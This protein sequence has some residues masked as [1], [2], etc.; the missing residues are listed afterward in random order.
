MIAYRGHYRWV[1][2]AEQI[3]TLRRKENIPL[4]LRENGVYLITGGLGRIGL[5]L[6]KYLAERVR[7]KIALVDR[8]ELPAG[9]TPSDWDIYVSNQANSAQI[10]KQIH[11]LQAIIA[12]GGEVQIYKADVAD[13]D[14]MSG[15]VQ[16]IE[17]RFGSINGVVHAA[18]IVGE[19]AIKPIIETGLELSEIQFNPK[20]FGTLTLAKVFRDK[21]L[22]FIFLQSSLSS[23]LGG[24]GMAAY[25]SANYFM[26]VF[27]SAQKQNGGTPWISVDWDGW[28]FDGQH[29]QA[30]T[31]TELTM[32]S[33]EGVEVFDR[34]MSTEL[35]SRVIISTADMD[36]RINRW[37]KKSLDIDTDQQEIDGKPEKKPI[38]GYQRPDLQTPYLPPRNELEDSIVQT[39]EKV[40]G[41]EPIGVNDDF[42]EL[43]GHSLLAT[44][45]VSRLRDTFNVQLPLRRLFESAT[46]AGISAIL[47]DAGV[48][49]GEVWSDTDQIPQSEGFNKP[50]LPVLRDG[51]LQL[52][53]GQQRLWFLDQM[54]PESPLYNNFS[55]IKFA[56]DLNIEA[57]QYSMMKI[58]D[59]H[60]ILRTTFH[61]KGGRPIQLV[62]EDMVV[63][64]T[65][66]DLRD[67]DPQ[68]AD[69]EF[70]ELALAEARKPFYLDQG[71]MLRTS[72]IRL[73]NQ[74][75]IVLLTMHHI[76]SDG[77]S[78]RV[79][80]EEV[81]AF[82]SAYLDLEPAKI[83]SFNLDDLPIQYVDFAHW[84]RGWLQNEVLDQQL[85]YWREQL[86]NRV[87][88]TGNVEIYPDYP[89]PAF[90]TS[91]GAS[92]WF[93]MPAGLTA[94]LVSLSKKTGVTLFMLLMAA[95]KTLIFRYTGQIDISIGTPIANRTRIETESLIGF[96]LNTLVMRTDLSGNPSF[97]DLLQRE[98]EVAL[99][100]YAHQD[101]PFEMV[102]EALQPE[103]DLSR[104]PFFQIIFDL[105]ESPLTEL[106]LPGLE[107]ASLRVDSGTA[108]FD[109]AL[110][111]EMHTDNQTTDKLAGFFNYNID[112]YNEQTISQ[113][114]NHWIRLIENAVDNPA[115]PI[116]E[117]EIL[118]NAEKQTLLA[119]WSQR[120]RSK[121][122]E[123]FVQDQFSRQ[124]LRTPTAIAITEVFGIFAY[125]QTLSYME[126]EQ[127][128]NQLAHYLKKLGVGPDK[129][130]GVSLRRSIDMI[131]ALLG[132]LKAGG[133]FLPLD[134]TYPIGRV[135]YM[136]T[137]SDVDILLTQER[138]L[139]NL[140]D[141]ISST[142][143]IH[144]LCLDR[145]WDE[146]AQQDVNNPESTI[147]PSNLAYV[148][149]TSGST[150]LPK[151][152]MVTHNDF[153][154]H[155]HAISEHFEISDSD[156]I[157]QFASLNF[158]AAL[159]QIFTSL[160]AGANLFIRGEEIWPTEEFN[161]IVQKLDL[162]VVN[163]PPVYWHHWSQ[164][165]ADQN[166]GERG[167]RINTNK[168]L[169][170]VI[171]GGDVMQTESLALWQK[172]SPRTV[173]LLNAYGPTETTITSMTYEVDP[174]SGK[175]APDRLNR[176]PIGHPTVN[177]FVFILDRAGNPVPNGVPGELCIG[178]M[179]VARGYL[180]NPSLTAERF[181]PNQFGDYLSAGGVPAEWM[182]KLY[183]TGD[184]VRYQPDG[185][186]EFLGRIDDQ[187]KVRGFRIEIGEI[188]TVIQRHP[189]ISECAVILR[190]RRTDQHNEPDQEV[191]KQLVAYVVPVEGKEPS[192][193]E[194]FDHI[195]DYLPN[196]MV[197]A[198]II[199]LDN[200]PVSPSGKLDR[201]ALPEPE[202]V[203]PELEV[204][205]VAPRTPVEYELARLWTDALD[206]EWKN[207]QSPIG[208]HDNFFELGGHSL[209]AT[210]IISRVREKYQVDLPIRKVFETPTIA[211][212]AEILSQS[213]LESADTDEIDA[214]LRELESMSDEEAVALLNEE[215]NDPEVLD[216]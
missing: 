129:L 168:S 28:M 50:I 17:S 25:A 65:M 164:Y 75:F 171:I 34:L 158:D 173:R 95:L 184:L 107:I 100:A 94:K 6:A 59:R 72:I 109:L 133:A 68:D 103:R 31:R 121:I 126:L 154:N 37:I 181:I 187:V 205:F 82:Y 191:E 85:D 140:P 80:I 73:T 188:E 134:P 38:S 200:L 114:I 77:W 185:E 116:S 208:V 53:Y 67:L 199:F 71:P 193:S 118:S 5:T 4:N 2:G 176:I 47:Q 11:Q 81:A 157:L 216:E 150:G 203:R 117:L 51:D 186:I 127:R 212:L 39:W 64:L 56:G 69:K 41:I 159:E 148:I 198:A 70:E 182:N 215:S 43:G 44:Q 170:L 30:R 151:G 54:E 76:I 110:S 189:L 177:R 192:V 98:R 120:G 122:L 115:K 145:D 86:A 172:S 48:M 163:I 87:G 137:D 143:K 162:S 138:L 8:Y 183:R 209:L 156:R 197:P 24:L 84:Q 26:D 20:I 178:G 130:V 175:V 57:L 153:V 58:V 124:A 33:V 19:K 112:L 169:R 16:D 141:Q 165:L 36:E 211:G 206:I 196:Y 96:I 90:Q 22:D 152:V 79:L 60:E 102:V 214:L 101:V 166:K 179:G 104:S 99:G 201:R 147:L 15:V 46:V 42:F 132:V 128:S 108:K 66:I 161:R 21:K 123:E 52:S 93:E 49:P 194:L 135:A 131:V 12:A 202:A 62:H 105:Q 144:R 9:V 139:V 155:I 61:D 89:R 27:A 146:I 1:E 91:N 213:L 204:A 106:M 119:D 180:N 136:L 13:A 55:A 190:T 142:K 3:N 63:P 113:L 83:N 88:S 23:V 14:Q 195:R 74:E 78:V 7:A 125:G 149:Y 174:H 32:D 97:E 40:L 18:G 92:I 167:K 210:Q 29:E 10:D 35:I 207:G 160:T 111:M 45:L